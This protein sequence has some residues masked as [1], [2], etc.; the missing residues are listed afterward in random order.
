MKLEIS[1]FIILFLILAVNGKTH[2]NKK[3][4][5]MRPRFKR[6]VRISPEIGK[7]S[8]IKVIHQTRSIIP[9][10]R[11]VHSH[12]VHKSIPLSRYHVTAQNYIH[13]AKLAYCP[14]QLIL[15][16]RCKACHFVLNNYKTFFIHSVNQN[17]KRLFQFVILY[18][19]VK[20]EI[21]ISF[22]GP[23]TEQTIFFNK[24]YKKGFVTVKEL[25]E[26]VKIENYYWEIYSKYMRNILQKKINRIVRNSKR[27][28]YRV[29]FIGHSFGGSLAVLAA[30]DLV[31]LNLVKTNT[32][33][34]SPII[35]TFGQLRIG[36][37]FF[38]EAANKLIKIMR[39]MRSDD[40]VTRVPSCVYDASIGLFKCY[41]RVASIIKHYPIFKK[42]FVIYRN[43]IRTY[44]KTIVKQFQVTQHTKVHYHTYYSQP[45]GTIIL[46]QGNNFRRF[47]LCKF[48]KGV[49]VCEE[50]IILPDTFSPSVHRFY[51]GVNVEL[52]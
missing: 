16:K 36:D 8:H 1:V 33:I 30:Y 50:K 40:F 9:Q 39:F 34:N 25:G 18:S 2:K 35:Y 4:K 27:N 38:V 23:K 5:I 37:N 13:V 51:F 24:V 49:P 31:K 3:R 43:G 47:S 15:A 12:L 21:L 44:R 46:Y 14:K 41:K 20:K 45:L 52:C 11:G 48:N 7:H 10:T 22:S 42:Y 32:S 6:H 26:N 17:K 29:V 28:K 19:D